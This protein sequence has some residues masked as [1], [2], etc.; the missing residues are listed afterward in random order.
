MLLSLLL[1]P[2]KSDRKCWVSRHEHPFA[3]GR[4]SHRLCWCAVAAA[5]LM[6]L[7]YVLRDG[8]IDCGL[9]S[10]LGGPSSKPSS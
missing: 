10:W 4:L 3:V 8:W 2:C 7:W 6:L 5:G 1:L 9:L